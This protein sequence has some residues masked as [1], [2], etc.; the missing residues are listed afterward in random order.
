MGWLL[1]PLQD[2]FEWTFGFIPALGP[3]I[4][5]SIIALISFG[6]VVWI[7]LMFRYQKDE[8]SNSPD[9]PI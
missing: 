9:N 6:I 2:L 8:V 5:N 7:A 1:Y 3:L 4:N